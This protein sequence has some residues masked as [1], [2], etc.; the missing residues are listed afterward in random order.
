MSATTIDSAASV[1]LTT[2]PRGRMALDGKP[3][4][5]GDFRDAL[6]RDGYAVIKGAVPRERADSYS[7]A[8]YGYIEGL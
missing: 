4:N 7:S 5:Y 2:A 3:S 8:F 1:M 6:N